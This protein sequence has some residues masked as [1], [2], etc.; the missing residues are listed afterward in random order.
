MCVCVGT[1]DVQTT[2]A[3]AAESEWSCAVCVCV[4]LTAQL[5]RVSAA[6]CRRD[7]C[8]HEVYFCVCPEGG[9]LGGSG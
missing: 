4:P 3:M 1:M 6:H 8:V 2:E 9:L 7:G 5:R